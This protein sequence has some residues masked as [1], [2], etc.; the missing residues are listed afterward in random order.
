MAEGETE[1]EFGIGGS[2]RTC[3]ALDGATVPSQLCSHHVPSVPIWEH[4]PVCHTTEAP[5]PGA[6]ASTW[7]QTSG[8][9]ADTSFSAMFSH[10]ALR[11]SRETSQ[12]PRSPD[13]PPSSSAPGLEKPA[14][15][16]GAFCCAA[17]S[18][19]TAWAQWPRQ[20]PA[21]TGPV[22]FSC[23]ACLRRV[24]LAKPDTPLIFNAGYWLC[25]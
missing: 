21:A 3:W 9:L 19:S 24:E 5:V 7:P 17:G 6:N 25:P 4:S 22:R 16:C 2:S 14:L 23:P 13:L 8:S 20:R 1:V 18:P 15:T 12:H 11:A 10:A